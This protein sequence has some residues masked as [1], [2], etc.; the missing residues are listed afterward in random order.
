MPAHSSA[1]AGKASAPKRSASL[2]N[3][4]AIQYS[5]TRK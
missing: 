3:A 5:P 2:K 1:T 4:I